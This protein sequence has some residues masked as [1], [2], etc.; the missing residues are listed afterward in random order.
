MKYKFGMCVYSYYI[1]I[2]IRFNH[3]LKTVQPQH[4]NKDGEFANTLIIKRLKT[5]KWHNQQKVIE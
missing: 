1:C 5:Q 2:A 4:F 3:S